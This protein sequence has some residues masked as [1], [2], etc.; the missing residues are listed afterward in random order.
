M[1][2]MEISIKTGILGIY[3]KNQTLDQTWKFW[4]NIKI[5]VKNKNRNFYSEMEI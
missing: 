1:P 2:K 3:A 4:S 5:F